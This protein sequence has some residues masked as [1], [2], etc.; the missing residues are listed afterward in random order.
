[1]AA[2]GSLRVEALSKNYLP[3]GCPPVQVLHGVSLAFAPGDYVAV[4]GPSGSGK[5]TF[6]A[7]LGC[8]DTP[9]GG[10][11]WID[12]DDVAGLDSDALSAL[13]N[14]VFGFVF[15][16]F[17]LLP[18]ATLLDNVALPMLYAGRSR[19]ERHARAAELLAQV[20]LAGLERRYPTQLSGGQQQRVAI[21]RALANRPAWLLAD[22][23]TGNLDS[24]TSG[25]IMAIFDRLNAEGLAIVLVTHEADIAAHARRLVRFADGQVIEDRPLDPAAATAESAP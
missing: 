16:G 21:A 11:Y 17:H 24:H 9:S 1:M 23:P 22:E 14:R 15:Q 5:S 12:G 6:L 20:G 25:E 3:P 4:M 10:H 7:L 19:R 13:R 8:L 18:R 2:S